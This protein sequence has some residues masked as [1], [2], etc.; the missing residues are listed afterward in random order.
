M[1]RLLF[2]VIIIALL[3]T[4]CVEPLDKGSFFDY[5]KNG[6]VAEGTWKEND[7]EYKIKLT[8]GKITDGERENLI[9]EF[10]QP[11]TLSGTKFVFEKGQLTATL[12]DMTLTVNPEARNK[13]FRLANMFSLKGEGIK[14]IKVNKEG[15]TVAQGTQ[16]KTAWSVTTDEKGNPCYIEY[17]SSSLNITSFELIKE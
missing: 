15:K 16:D 14:S 12:G 9:L 1:K 7:C 6:A 11:E 17:G 2:T 10:L 5:Q 8:V 3:L 4:S 13:I